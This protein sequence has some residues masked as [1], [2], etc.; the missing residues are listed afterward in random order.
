MKRKCHHLMAIWM[1]LEGIMLNEI[2]QQRKTNAV[3]SHY[4]YIKSKKQKTNRK[5]TH[6]R[7]EQKGSCHE[8]MLV[9]GDKFLG[10]CS[11]DIEY[12]MVTIVKNNVLYT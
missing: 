4:T 5:T 9:K 3:Q 12:S 7:R 8:E 1:D 11:R 2:N 6:R 10:T